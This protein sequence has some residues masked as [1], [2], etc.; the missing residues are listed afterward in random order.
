MGPETFRSGKEKLQ[1]GQ[2]PVPGH[3]V[4]HRGNKQLLRRGTC[5]HHGP[6]QGVSQTG[7]LHRPTGPD[8]LP[9][10]GKYRAKGQGR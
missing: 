2:V 4:L 3:R 1:G 9:S 5:R 8:E 6:D 10:E 7:G